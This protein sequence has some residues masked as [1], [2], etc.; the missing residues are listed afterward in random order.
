MRVSRRAIALCFSALCGCAG[1]STST[2]ASTP[3]AEAAVAQE[4]SPSEATQTEAEGSNFEGMVAVVSVADH[5]A[6]LAWHEKWIG[7]KPDMV[8][9]EGVA[10]WR[11]HGESWLQLALDPERAGKGTVIINVNDLAAQ[12]EICK[13][14][15]VEL[16]ETQDLGFI[17][18]AQTADP[19]G[20]LVVFV[21]SMQ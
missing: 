6:A 17:K 12:R 2:A 8:P 15:G 11:L 18:M 4:A 1:T 16:G 21:Q 19:E 9:V 3:V 14:P 7:R 5:A 20:N 10:E 13:A